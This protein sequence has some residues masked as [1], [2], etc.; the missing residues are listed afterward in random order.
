MSRPTHPILLCRSDPS[1]TPSKS[2]PTRPLTVWIADPP[3]TSSRTSINA[4]WFRH[5]KSVYKDGSPTGIQG[6]PLAA[7]APAVLDRPGQMQGGNL[8]GTGQVHNRARWLEHP[9]ERPRREL[10]LPASPHAR[11]AGR[12]P[13]PRRSGALPPIPCPRCTPGVPGP[14]PTAPAR[15]CARA[16]RPSARPHADRSASRIRRAAPRRG[17]QCG[18]RAGRWSAMLRARDG[19]RRE[20]RSLRTVVTARCGMMAV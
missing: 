17:Y 18:P 16:R 9:M 14:R 13:P 3:T 1:A 12:W 19:E 6:L 7:S 5:G 20:Q 8:L 2:F 15:A 10:Q 11:A 4:V